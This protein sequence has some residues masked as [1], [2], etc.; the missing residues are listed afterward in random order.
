MS[1]IEYLSKS[2][3]NSLSH[4]YHLYSPSLNLNMKW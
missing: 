2:V 4:I 1:H 3:C